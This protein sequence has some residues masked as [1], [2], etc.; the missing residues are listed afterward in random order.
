MLGIELFTTSRPPTPTRYQ[1][2]GGEAGVRKPLVAFCGKV[3]ADPT[4]KPFFIEASM[5]KLRLMQE[6]FSATAF[7]GPQ[8]DTDRQLREVQ[9]EA[10]SAT[11][12]A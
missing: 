1:Q 10:G 4:L 6:E 3:L 5:D 11:A 12:P 8:H 7:D 2:L 9:R